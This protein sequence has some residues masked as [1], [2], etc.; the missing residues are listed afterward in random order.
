MKKILFAANNLEIGGIEKA[1]VTLL[2]ALESIGKYQITLVLE[3]KIGLLL[4]ELNEEINIIEYKPN[5][6]RIVLIRK[7]INFIKRL[8]F[9]RKYK[10]KFDFSASFATYSKMSSFV[11]RTASRNSTL[12]GH[13][14]YIELYNNKE[15]VINFFKSINY[16]EFKNIVF[17]SE[18]GKKSFISI[19]PKKKE[20]VI[21]CNNLIDERILELANENID[22]EKEETTFLNV[23]RHDE[24]QKRLTRLINVAK[25]LKDNGYKFKMLFVGDGPDSEN[26]KE[27][28]KEYGLENSVIFLGKKPNPYPYFLVSDAVVLTS[29]Y[30]GYPV[31]FLESMALGK[32]IIT[33]DV[34][35]SSSIKNGGFGIVTQKD[36]NSIYEAM[37]EFIKYGYKPNAFDIKEYNK[38]IYTRLENII[39]GR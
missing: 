1:L 25:R 16:D 31:V 28:V 23:G 34:S 2:N 6:N 3:N 33:T 37:E 36:D 12:W 7:M 8:N 32:P 15:E 26:Y 29:D 4:K 21:V 14:D 5:K 24:K 27:K 18:E 39:E 10:N 17:V 19:F 13:A 9:S 35:G 30:E 20:D 11:A 38:D 22:I